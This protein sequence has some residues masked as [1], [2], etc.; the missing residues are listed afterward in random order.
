MLLQN[1]ASAYD[2]S[3][4][5]LGGALVELGDVFLQPALRTLQE[6]AAAANLAPP[7]VRTSRFGADAVAAGA[8]ALA[9]YRLTRP[10]VPGG[11]RLIPQETD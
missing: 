5:V 1:L 2:P 10:L 8:A 7:E 9:R 6:Y 4:I 3:C 11:A